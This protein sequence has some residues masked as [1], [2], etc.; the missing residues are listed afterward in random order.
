MPHKRT[1]VLAFNPQVWEQLLERG[2]PNEIRC[3]L[4][5]IAAQNPRSDELHWRLMDALEAAFERGIGA[6]KAIT[7]REFEDKPQGL[8]Q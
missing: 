8:L 2:T 1:V 5:E 6:G 7:R 4:M 3:A